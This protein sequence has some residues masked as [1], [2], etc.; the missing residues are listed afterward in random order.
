MV[1]A[2]AVPSRQLDR[3]PAPSLS[4]RIAHACDSRADTAHVALIAEVLSLLAATSRPAAPAGEPQHLREPLSPA[5]T[6]VVRYLPTNLTA[7]E[8]TGQLYLSVNTVQAHMRLLCQKLG[9]H[10]RSVAVGQA[11]ALGLLASSARRP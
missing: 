1:L 8:I 5:E 4:P 7:S 10:R 6:R 9:A 3:L 2:P 11:R